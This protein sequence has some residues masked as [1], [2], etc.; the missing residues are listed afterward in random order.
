MST[1]QSD[2]IVI[3]DYQFRG[4]AYIVSRDDINTLNDE[5]STGNLFNDVSLLPEAIE[6]KWEENETFDSFFDAVREAGFLVTYSD[7][8]ALGS[9]LTPCVKSGKHFR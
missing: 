7:L 5:D 8:D 2:Y 9:N 1:P 4:Q 6:I 3:T